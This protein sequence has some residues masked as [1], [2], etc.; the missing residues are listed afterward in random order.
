MNFHD[1]LKLNYN[2]EKNII[3]AFQFCPVSILNLP[4]C[5]LWLYDKK[6]RLSTFKIQ[7]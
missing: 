6:A 7:L 1:T 4:E 5:F 2:T 3:G